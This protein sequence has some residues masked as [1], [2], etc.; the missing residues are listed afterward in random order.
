MEK[1]QWNSIN[2]TQNGLKQLKNERSSTLHR[3]KKSRSESDEMVWARRKN[4]WAEYG[5]KGEIGREW[6]AAASYTYIW[7]DEWV[8]LALDIGGMIV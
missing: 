4:G 6:R 8:K 2:K 1:V 7:M 3:C 5:Q